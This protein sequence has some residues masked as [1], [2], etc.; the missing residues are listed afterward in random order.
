[1]TAAVET[2]ISVPMVAALD[3]MWR[4]IR[5]R[6]DD[7]PAVVITLG[8][9]TL[10]VAAGSTKLGH[11][12]AARWQHGDDA[13]AELFIGGEGLQRGAVPVLGTLLHEA[14]HGVANVRELNDTSRQGRYHNSTFRGLAEELGIT[15]EH[16]QRL[17]W[18]TTTVPEETA[19]RYAAEVRALE[20]AITAWRHAEARAVRGGGR[21][22]NNNPTAYVCSCTPARRIRVAESVATLGPIV[23]SVCDQEFSADE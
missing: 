3:R 19:K 7:V 22:S 18:S 2:S 23:C 16:S 9:G 13:V 12:A 14:A 15:V 21:T 8:S 5:R 17:G 20:K 4:A 1:M 10:G 6:H 11:F